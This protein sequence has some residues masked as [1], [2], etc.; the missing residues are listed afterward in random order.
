MTRRLL[1]VVIVL[2]LVTVACTS[3]L[4]KA[5]LVYDDAGGTYEGRTE[6]PSGTTLN[7]SLANEVDADVS[8]GIWPLPEGTTQEQIFA[9]GMDAIKI[10]EPIMQE[11]GPKPDYLTEPHLATFKTPGQY[12]AACTEWWPTEHDGQGLSYVTMINVTE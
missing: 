11:F 1:P 12:G 5:S 7:F 10:G 8:F 2:M 9:T 4:E 3:W 6:V